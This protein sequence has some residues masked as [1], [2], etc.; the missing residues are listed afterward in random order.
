M[1]IIK[2]ETGEF[3]YHN[4]DDMMAWLKASWE[5]AAAEGNE[6]MGI[7]AKHILANKPDK[8]AA[9]NAA[10]EIIEMI[11]DS[12]NQKMRSKKSGETN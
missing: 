1:K 3:E 8:N 11:E 7:L 9:K 4:N 12:V 10:A 6:G 2:T 5:K